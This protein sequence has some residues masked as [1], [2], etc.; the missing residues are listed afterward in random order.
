MI[1]SCNKEP[2]VEEEQAIR[3]TWLKDVI[4]DKYE[5]IDY[6]FYKAD[7]DLINHKY[8]RDNHLLTLRCEDDYDHTFKKSYYAFNLLSKIFKEY[9]YVFKTNTSTYINIPLLNQFIQELPDDEDYYSS[10]VYSLSNIGAPAPLDLYGR[11]NGL[12]LSKKHIDI[13]IKEGISFLYIANGPDDAYISNILNSYWIKNGENYIDHIKS[14]AHGWYRCIP[15]NNDFKHQLCIFGNTN[16]DWDFLK[17]F[18]SIQI[19]IYHQD[20]S[21]EKEKH[22]ELYKVFQENKYDDEELRKQVEFN[23]EYSK[24]YSVFIGSILGYMNY[25][26]WKRADKLKLYM[27]EQDHKAT[28]D[29]AYGIKNKWL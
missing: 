22:Y 28:D 16:I 23:K 26:D 14:F 4:D 3:E 1:M 8:E 19:K 24:N 9:D 12:I 7:E 6:L 29:V 13:I 5:N 17:K 2:F 10:D 27:L 11:G 15:N 20:R 18:I 25:N 21:N